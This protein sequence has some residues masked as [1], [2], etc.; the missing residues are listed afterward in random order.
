MVMRKKVGRLQRIESSAGKNIA[1]L[2]NDIT[3]TIRQIDRS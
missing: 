3:Y 1:E 2:E